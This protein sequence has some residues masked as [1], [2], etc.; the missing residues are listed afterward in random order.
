MNQNS[1]RW[2][3][4]AASIFF[5]GL[6]AATAQAQSNDALLNKLVSKGI[7]TAEEAKELSKD[8]SAAAPTAKLPIATWVSG[9]K[10]SG[11][12]RGRYDGVFQHSDTT[13][14]GDAIEDLNGLRYRFRF[15]ATATM[16]DQFEAGLRLA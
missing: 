9:L 1:A 4:L 3:K 14:A 13:G 2:A 15:G 8:T 7:L 6:A 5:C 10:F 16:S 12:F 11:D